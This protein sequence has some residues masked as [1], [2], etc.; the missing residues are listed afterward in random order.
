ML[1]AIVILLVIGIVWALIV[2]YV[3]IPPVVNTVITI[4]FV[5]VAAVFILQMFGINVGHGMSFK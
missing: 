2:K 1:S 5:L 4:I 3:G